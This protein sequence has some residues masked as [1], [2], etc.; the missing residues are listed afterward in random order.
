[1]R[2][3]YRILFVNM[4]VRDHIGDKAKRGSVFEL[5]SSGAG[6]TAVALSC[7]HHDKTSLCD[8]LLKGS[9]TKTI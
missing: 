2:N 8:Y 1:M 6:Q 3:S 7:E 9:A 5:Q 4:K